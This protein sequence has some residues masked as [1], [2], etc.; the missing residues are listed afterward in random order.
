ME[1]LPPK[2]YVF[3]PNAERELKKLEKRDQKRVFRTLRDW[4]EGKLAPQIEKIKSQPDF[5]RVR[6]G[7][8]RLVYYPLTGS[9]L[10][11][12]LIRDRKNAYKNLGDLSAMLKTAKRKLGVA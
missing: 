7:D 4:R 11:I 6:A 2:E 8:F 9:R 5:Y 10:V 12:L 1:Q 3:S